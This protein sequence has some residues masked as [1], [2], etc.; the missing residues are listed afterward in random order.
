TSA[1]SGR[2]QEGPLP[3]RLVAMIAGSGPL[4]AT[5]G[6]R[7]RNTYRMTRTHLATTAA[8]LLLA[9]PLLAG[10]QTIFRAGT[11]SVALYATVQDKN[12]RLI[13][14]LNK[15][16]FEIYDDGKKQTMTL[17]ENAIQPVTVVVMLDTS[18]SM[19]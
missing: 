2:L 7:C 4:L 3:R 10:Q 11:R 16:D 14:N 15:D 8:A 1:R 6:V 5:T 19:T 17:F 18:G 13:P 9:C 12:G